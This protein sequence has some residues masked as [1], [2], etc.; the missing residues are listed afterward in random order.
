MVSKTDPVYLTLIQRLDL[1]RLPDDLKVLNLPFKDLQDVDL[2]YLDAYIGKRGWTLTGLSL[3]GN[4]LKGFFS[5]CNL[6]A[7]QDLNLSW[8]RMIVSP[9]FITL[10]NLRNL[11][12]Y[13]NQL[14]RVP[15]F[16]LPKLER[17]YLDWNGLKKIPPFSLPNLEVLSLNGNE[18]KTV[19]TAL[20]V[21]KLKQL[22]L[23]ANQLTS[24]PILSLGNLKELNLLENQLEISCPNVCF[25][26]LRILAV[27]AG[28]E[29]FIPTDLHPVMKVFSDS[30]LSFDRE[31]GQLEEIFI[32]PEFKYYYIFTSDILI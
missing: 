5:F 7:L 26:K 25:P 6:S 27:S 29:A 9:T 11:Y 13:G 31:I 18:L 15:S 23:S 20:H 8:N 17:L 10:P 28:S 4:N 22:T 30:N 16:C 19:P 2:V 12:L 1:D 32:V 21:P 24:V 3:K 14:T